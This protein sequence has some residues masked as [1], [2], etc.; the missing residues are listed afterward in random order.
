[1]RTNRAE[2]TLR[3]NRAEVA[4]RTNRA[5]VAL[6]TNRAEVTLRT[7][8]AEVTFAVVRI[9]RIVGVDILVIILNAVAVKVPTMQTVRSGHAFGPIRSLCSL[10]TGRAITPVGPLFP[11]WPLR[12]LSSGGAGS[13]RG[14]GRVASDSSS[15]NTDQ[16]GSGR[17]PSNAHNERGYRAPHSRTSTECLLPT[18]ARWSCRAAMWPPSSTAPMTNGATS[19]RSSSA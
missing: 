9:P 13:V 16:P 6:R 10:R 14:R 8:R 3:T 2:V 12:S 11:H 1:M 19:G 17:E 18:D 5:E 7:N 4:L 15:G